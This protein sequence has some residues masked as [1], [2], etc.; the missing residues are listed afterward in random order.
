MTMTTKELLALV[1]SLKESITDWGDN[2]RNEA[3]VDLLAHVDRI[4]LSV[5]QGQG[6]VMV[7]GAYVD[8]RGKPVLTNE[9]DNMTPAILAR[10][11]LR[12]VYELTETREPDKPIPEN[13]RHDW[14]TDG[15]GD[16]CRYCKKREDTY[17][18]PA[19]AAEAVRVTKQMCYRAIDAYTEA[20]G[21]G[22]QQPCVEGMY[23]ALDAAMQE[24]E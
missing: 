19:Q 9:G 21:E 23:A 17:T 13:C 4:E 8:P 18:P 24:G 1:D 16:Y 3:M 5:A 22:W 14:A 7:P 10:R 20:V 15:M 11:G 2:M 12:P 6:F